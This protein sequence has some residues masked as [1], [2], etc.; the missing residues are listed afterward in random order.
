MTQK[1]FPSENSLIPSPLPEELQNLTQMEEMLIARVFPV[2]SVYTKP[3]GGGGG[4]KELTKATALI[5]LKKLN[6]YFILWLGIQ[7][8]HQL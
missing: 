6:R 3:G 8:N 2:I 1:N 7:K 5:F 4:G